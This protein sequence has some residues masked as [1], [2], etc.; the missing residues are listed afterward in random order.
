[1]EAKSHLRVFI[2]DIAKPIAAFLGSDSSDEVA[3]HSVE[4][5][6]FLEGTFEAN[7]GELDKLG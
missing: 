4:L 1:M 7:S 5:G 2:T 3:R 6:V